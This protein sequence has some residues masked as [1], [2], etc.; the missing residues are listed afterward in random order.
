[1]N[2]VL[3]SSQDQNEQQLKGEENE[4]SKESSYEYEMYRKRK[5]FTFLRN[6]QKDWTNLNKKILSVYNFLKKNEFKKK[7][8]DDNPEKDNLE[9]IQKSIEELDLKINSI[10]EANKK[11]KIVEEKIN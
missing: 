10:I 3:A 9:K 6:F 5:G 8:K 2:V 4:D 7:I 11:E 1:M